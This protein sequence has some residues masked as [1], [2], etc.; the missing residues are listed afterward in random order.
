M[1][2]RLGSNRTIKGVPKQQVAL[3]CP[4]CFAFAEA[5]LKPRPILRLLESPAA[6]RNSLI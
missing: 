3:S 6:P 2:R 1:A 4:K 5:P